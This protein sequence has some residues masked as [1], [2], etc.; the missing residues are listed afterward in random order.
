MKADKTME[1]PPAVV[2]PTLIIQQSYIC[3]QACVSVG[4]IIQLEE[5]REMVTSKVLGNWQCRIML[6]PRIKYSFAG[7]TDCKVINYMSINH[8]ILLNC[9]TRVII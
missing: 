7:G 5:W 6:Q 2:F 8:L 1:V 3:W 4:K 9:L